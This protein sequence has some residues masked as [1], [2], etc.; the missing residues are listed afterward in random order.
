MR[1]RS[2]VPNPCPE[3]WDALTPEERAP[4]DESIQEIVERQ[5]RRL[6]R[7]VCAAIAPNARDRDRH[8]ELAA[9]IVTAYFGTRVIAKS[10]MSGEMIVATRDQVLAALAS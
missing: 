6:H 5:I 4:V 8:D 7:A 3:S 10:G 9:Y 2:P 1:G